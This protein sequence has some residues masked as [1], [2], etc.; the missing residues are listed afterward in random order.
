MV[1]SI[2]KTKGRAL[3]DSKKIVDKL[4]Y[5]NGLNRGSM[6]IPEPRSPFKHA[7]F[8]PTTL[9]A[10]SNAALEDAMFKFE[11]NPNDIFDGMQRDY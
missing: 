1:D 2:R 11:N 6:P 3:E 8:N 5:F 10:A 9:K 7:E 4:T